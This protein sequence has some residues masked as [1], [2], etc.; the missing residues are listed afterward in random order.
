M[1]EAIFLS[2]STTR[3]RI[4]TIKLAF[5]SKKRKMVPPLDGRATGERKDEK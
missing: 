2:S 5:H 1:K 4:A 3:I